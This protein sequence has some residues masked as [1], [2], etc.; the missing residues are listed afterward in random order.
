M[1][2]ATVQTGN[3][4][5]RASSRRDYKAKG[6]AR[7]QQLAQPSPAAKRGYYDPKVSVWLSVDPKAHWYPGH[8]PY[9]FS[10]NNPINLV[11]PNG[12][13][14]EGAGFWNNLFYSDKR[15]EAMLM[16]SEKGSLEKTDDGWR[17]ARPS[18]NSS[19]NNQGD[20]EGEM[21]NEVEVIELKDREKGV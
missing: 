8:S 17:V 2:A 20:F 18:E 11:D 4:Y 21:L 9:N 14:V 5:Y 12:Q 1:T 15:K 6:A 13:W 19:G 16:A 3:Y 7:R 10:L